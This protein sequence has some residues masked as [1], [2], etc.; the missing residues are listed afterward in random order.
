MIM[1][2][3]LKRVLSDDV[4]R[5][6]LAAQVC[7]GAWELIDDCNSLDDA[8]QTAKDAADDIWHDDHGNA[9]FGISSLPDGSGYEHRLTV[10]EDGT[11]VLETDGA[12]VGTV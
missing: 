8:I 7:G 6:E 5:M 12:V 9:V 4:G 2:D 3:L 1:D 10:Y 11:A